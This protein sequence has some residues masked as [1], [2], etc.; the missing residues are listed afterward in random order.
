VKKFELGK[1]E[2]MDTG[3][4]RIRHEMAE[5]GSPPPEFYADRDSFTVVLR[6]RHLSPLEEER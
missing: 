1:A 4:H 6:S 3:I 2:R 5:L